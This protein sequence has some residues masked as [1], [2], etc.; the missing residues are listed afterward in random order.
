MLQT[1]RPTRA[2]HHAAGSCDR[3]ACRRRYE[4]HA[5][6]RA[7]VATR[8]SRRRMALH[9]T[10]PHIPL[11]IPLRS[12][13]QS[14][15]SRAHYHPAEQT[16]FYTLYYTSHRDPPLQPV[17]GNLQRPSSS[18]RRR[19]NRRGTLELELGE[20]A[21]VHLVGAVGDAQRARRRP[22]VCERR[23]LADAGAAVH[24]DGR[25]EDVER[26]CGRDDLGGGD[27]AARRLVADP[28]LGD[29][30]GEVGKN[31]RIRHHDPYACRPPSRSTP[32]HPLAA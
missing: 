21:Q 5:L 29:V 2:R 30:E 32:C 17:A 9:S 7:S 4:P 14:A 10:P 8:T 19:R 25:V 11:H 31:T 13:H 18:C 16:P 1:R 23:V 20:R 28:V 27:L 3:R 26:D 15:P 12:T 22:Q 24:L 6:R